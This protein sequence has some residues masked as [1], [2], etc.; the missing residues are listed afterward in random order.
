MPLYKKKKPTKKFAVFLVIENVILGRST[1]I[2][3][4]GMGGRKYRCALIPV[5]QIASEIW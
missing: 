5:E 1:G 4:W 2:P 3:G